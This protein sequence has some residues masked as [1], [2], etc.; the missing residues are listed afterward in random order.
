M[1]KIHD[2]FFFQFV[3]LLALAHAGTY[4]KTEVEHSQNPAGFAY[5]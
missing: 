2:L 3:T 4:E 5:K 1:L